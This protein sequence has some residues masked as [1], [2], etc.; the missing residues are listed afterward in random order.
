MQHSIFESEILKDLVSYFGQVY[1]ICLGLSK[2]FLDAEDLAQESYLRAIRKIDSLNDSHLSREWLVKIARNTCLNYLSKKH[3][4]R[5]FLF[6]SEN[7]LVEKITPEFSIVKKEKHQI[8]K[9]AVQNLPKIYKD[10][11]ILREYRDL[12]YQEIAKTLGLKEGTVM[13]RLCRARQGLRNQLG[14]N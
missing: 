11:F 4:N 2:N 9:R 10:V 6:R 14:G 3:L 13:S 12:S 7:D 1:R 5:T 8:F